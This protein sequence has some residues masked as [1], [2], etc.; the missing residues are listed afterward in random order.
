MESGVPFLNRIPFLS[1]LF[2]R[3]GN[4]ESY[5]KLLILLTARVIIPTEFEPEPLPAGT[6]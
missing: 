5:R 1:F 2:S 3:K 6:R 4:F